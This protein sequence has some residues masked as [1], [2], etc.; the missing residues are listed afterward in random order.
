MSETLTK[1]QKDDQI[2]KETND[3]KAMDVL[4]EIQNKKPF[5]AE[6]LS[7]GRGRNLI[8]PLTHS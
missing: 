8:A 7:R 2:F 4:T 1:Q 6:L 3:P 5:L